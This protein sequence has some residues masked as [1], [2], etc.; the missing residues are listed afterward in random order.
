MLTAS[1]CPTS[2][3]TTGDTM[4]IEQTSQDIIGMVDCTPTDNPRVF[5]ADDGSILVVGRNEAVKLTDLND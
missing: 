4:K 5:I 2:T 1:Y 3:L